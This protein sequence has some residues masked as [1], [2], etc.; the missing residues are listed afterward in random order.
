MSNQTQT[1]NQTKPL[2]GKSSSLPDT[3]LERLKSIVPEE[4]YGEILAS[5]SR[6]K[7]IIFRINTLKTTVE[8]AL[9]GI[10]ATPVNYFK[11]TFQCPAEYRNTLTHSKAFTD[12]HIYI[13]SLSSML[14]PIILDPQPGE[15]ILDLAAAP[16][17][18]TTQMAVM[19]NNTGRIA[20]VE[21]V[22]SRF[23]KLKDN[24][25]QQGVTC[26]D[27]YCKDGAIVWRSCENR[28]DRVLLD[29]PCSSE[30]RFNT[31]EP[32]SFYYWNERKIKEM[33]RKQWQLLYSAFR[34]LKPGG[35]LVYSTCT[36]APEENERQIEKLIKKFG[37]QV[38]VEKID[39]P[40]ENIQ[41]GLP[42]ITN[43]IRI[44]PNALMD[45]FFICKVVKK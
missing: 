40:F 38:I 24:C 36:F 28:F 9:T 4:K 25:Q 19:M 31:N 16:G 30:G 17:S 2:E 21:K 6:K 43:A 22:K 20:A 10:E 45:G 7:P 23:F 8:N 42:P 1:K 35:T 18:K 27:F 34:S 11:N 33:A 41:T 15:E 12:G 44:L 32:K 29:A 3:F 39:L 13:Q 37:E 14:A 5:F 26:V